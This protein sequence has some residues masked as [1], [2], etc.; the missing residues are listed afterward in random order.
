MGRKLLFSNYTRP[1]PAHK[2]IILLLMIH[3]GKL[4][5]ETKESI[6]IPKLRGTTAVITYLIIIGIFAIEMLYIMLTQATSPYM[7]LYIELSVVAFII[8]T[9]INYLI[10][11]VKIPEAPK[12]P[13]VIVAPKV[14][15]AILPVIKKEE[16]K[17]TSSEATKSKIEIPKAIEEVP[18]VT[19]NI[20]KEN[21]TVSENTVIS[22]KE[23]IDENKNISEAI[24]ILIKLGYKE[25][26]AKVMVYKAYEIIGNADLAQL[27]KKSLT[28]ETDST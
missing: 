21:N 15:E 23:L 8:C 27:V 20:E 3:W 16:I 2:S 13:E 4:T 9:G 10:N 26:L 7:S 22:E 18:V 1:K 5:M 25:R 6:K 12:Q 28:L 24:S 11:I 14:I 19:S 17:D